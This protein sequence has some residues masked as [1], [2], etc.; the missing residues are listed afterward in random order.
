ML[1]SLPPQDLEDQATL[2]SSPQHLLLLAQEL[3]KD[4]CKQ[5]KD[6]HDQQLCLFSDM[7]KVI[8]HVWRSESY[9]AAEMQVTRR[10]Y[11]LQNESNRSS[12]TIQSQVSVLNT[13]W[14][15]VS[16]QNRVQK[17]KLEAKT[18]PQT[19]YSSLSKEIPIRTENILSCTY[20][21]IGV[22][23]GHGDWV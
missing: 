8:S 16:I 13:F 15:Q 12:V 17:H 4:H 14:F 9:V 3:T 18:P 6:M 23:S 7:C 5:S 22:T 1:Q 11:S 10:L 19:L 2:A 20:V 21:L